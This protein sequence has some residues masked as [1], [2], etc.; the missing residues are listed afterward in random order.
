MAKGH[1]EKFALHR[2]QV[3]TRHQSN[4]CYSVASEFRK[5][6]VSAAHMINVCAGTLHVGMVIH[7]VRLIPRVLKSASIL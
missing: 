5:N 7:A 6:E 3:E 4:L 1:F 2:N